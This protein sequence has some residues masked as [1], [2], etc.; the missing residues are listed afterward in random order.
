MQSRAGA[1]LAQHSR[2]GTRRVT[3]IEM[4]APGADLQTVRLRDGTREVS[5]I[6]LRM[7]CGGAHRKRMRVL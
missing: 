5:V 4:I 1:L 7:R 3:R 2:L 6:V